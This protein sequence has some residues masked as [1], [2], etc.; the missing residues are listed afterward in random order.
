MM[1]IVMKMIVTIKKIYTN[2]I[3]INWQQIMAV[4]QPYKLIDRTIKYERKDDWSS[5][6]QYYK[7]TERIC[8][9]F[10]ASARMRMNVENFMITY[11]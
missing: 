11:K 4:K 2:Q 10:Y 5:I 1:T 9:R 6:N 8:R 3:P 7:L